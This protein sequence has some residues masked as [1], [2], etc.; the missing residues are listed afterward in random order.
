[1]DGATTKNKD[2][3]LQSIKFLVSVYYEGNTFCNLKKIMVKMQTIIQSADFSQSL[4]DEKS[5]II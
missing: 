2:S 4:K 1:M 3:A 5:R